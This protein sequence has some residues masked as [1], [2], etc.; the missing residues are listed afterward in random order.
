MKLPKIVKFD[1]GV[2]LLYAKTK[3]KAT[4][5]VVSFFA[6]SLEDE[7]EGSAH[8][9]E[10]MLLKETKNRDFAQINKDIQ[11]VC[12][13][14]ALTSTRF[15]SI[16]AI[17]T[18]KLTNK[19]VEFMADILLNNKLNENYI[20]TEKGVI[21]EE[22]NRRLDQYKTSIGPYHSAQIF[23]GSFDY[24][25]TL[26]THDSI[27]SMSLEDLQNY[28]NKNYISQNFIM[29]VVS[30][31]S[32]RKIKKLYKENFEP[33][34]FV[35]PTASTKEPKPIALKDE[36]LRVVKNEELQQVDCLIS[37]IVPLG[38]E[39]YKNYT[40]TSYLKPL[41]G[42]YTSPVFTKLRNEG[43]T[44]IFNPVQVERDDRKTIL[45]FYFKT[46]PHKVKRVIDVMSGCFKEIYENG[47]DEQLFKSQ[48][49]NLQYLDDE[50]ENV[51]RIMKRAQN[52][53]DIY[54]SADKFR[55][56]KKWEKENKKLKLSYVNE[57]YKKV[58]S[59]NNKLYVTYLGNIEEKDVYTLDE[60]KGKLL[61]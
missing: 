32:L 43:L 18:N 17:R 11:E 28:K 31:N 38:F 51:E 42:E 20:E 22:L 48:T 21:H 8:F 41:M 59:K 33:K 19:T 46:S 55:K 37:I 3:K 24:P 45:R 27:E 58:L 7:K 14:N 1:N 56:F 29:S 44:Y 5:W 47:M 25:K 6:G 60:T 36:S 57:F 40:V 50:T 26:G 30:K 54:I 49:L 61:F 15:T 4:A 2:T 13:L 34:L 35:S 10:H 53:F 12:K 23:E 9:L 39:D 16:E 52:I